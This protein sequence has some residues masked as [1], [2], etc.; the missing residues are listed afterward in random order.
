[1]ADTGRPTPR[2]G[3]P[4]SRYA[5][6]RKAKPEQ[7]QYM[8]RISIGGVAV[9][10]LATVVMFALRAADRSRGPSPP[11]PVS[12]ER[13]ADATER[14]AALADERRPTLPTLFEGSLVDAKNG[15][16]FRE[17]F[18][19]R[20][21][22]FQMEKM[23]PEDVSKKTEMFD[24]YAGAIAQPDAFRGR[25]F[26]VQGLVGQLTAERLDSVF[27]GETDVYRG[28]LGQT[29]GSDGVVFD[30]LTPPPQFDLMRD[31]VE[32]D[33]LFY[34]TVRYETGSGHLV[35]IPYFLVKSLRVM[36]DADAP[37]PSQPTGKDAWILGV[38]FLVGAGW[39]VYQRFKIKQR[40][41]KGGWKAPR[42]LPGPAASSPGPTP[43]VPAGTDT[44]TRI[45]FSS[46]SLAAGA[47]E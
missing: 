4:G 2:G 34:R 19:M 24:D 10:G 13:V 7:P 25:W 20:H 18:G 14:L 21:L 26:R 45:D 47:A 29:D 46:S 17:T 16:D 43:S 35:E 11:T 39:V 27:W 41:K 42:P 31:V 12:Q 8:R 28:F 3:G 6:L 1:M 23:S 37:S 5:F 9:I 36:H 44:S 33:G 38:A 22:L 15:D 40:P 30:M 32:V